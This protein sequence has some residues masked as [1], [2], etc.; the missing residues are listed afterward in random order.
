MLWAVNVSGQSGGCDGG[1]RA[2]RL[3][4]L[5]QTRQH[6]V[7]RAFGTQ[8]G[9]F[10]ACFQE[11]QEDGIACCGTLSQVSFVDGSRGLR[12]HLTFLC[13]HGLAFHLDQPWQRQQL[14]F[15]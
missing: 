5:S 4:T 15:K 11:G 9:V 10:C 6:L 12:M 3:F 2:W 7:T 1:A 13:F 14:S 8:F